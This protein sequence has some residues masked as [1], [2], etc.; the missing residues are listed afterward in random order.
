M[1]YSYAISPAVSQF[2]HL[3]KPSEPWKWTEEINEV[4]KQAKKVITRNV[5]KRV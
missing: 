4:F 3:L 1:A 2:W 5:E